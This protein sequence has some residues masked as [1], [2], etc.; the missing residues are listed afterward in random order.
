MFIAGF[1]LSAGALLWYKLI[2]PFDRLLQ[3]SEETER[4]ECTPAVK[5]VVQTPELSAADKS[6]VN[7][8]NAL[9]RSRVV[10]LANAEEKPSTRAVAPAA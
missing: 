4:L 7:L 1:L 8:S 5:G 9:N 3:Q 10:P 2:V 6:L